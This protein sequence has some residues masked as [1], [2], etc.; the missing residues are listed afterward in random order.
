MPDIWFPYL[1]IAIEHLDKVAFTIFGIDIA[2]YGVIIACGV[3]AGLL[4]GRHLA[5]KSGQDPD[6]SASY[7]ARK[8]NP[9]R[10]LRSQKMRMTAARSPTV[11]CETSTGLSFSPGNTIRRYSC[12]RTNTQGIPRSGNRMLY[13]TASMRRPWNR[14]LTALPEP[15]PGQYRPV[16][17]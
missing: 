4:L 15:H 10:F 11:F 12:R 16:R 7:G 14:A 9:G 2:W 17:R 3:I 5:R 8:S 6:C 1:G 13:E